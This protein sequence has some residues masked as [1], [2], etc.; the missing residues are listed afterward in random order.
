MT[1]PGGENKRDNERSQHVSKQKDSFELNKAP[2]DN[3][4]KH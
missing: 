4:K 3:D 1:N 2:E